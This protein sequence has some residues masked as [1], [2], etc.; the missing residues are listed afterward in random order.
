M[1]LNNCELKGT[2]NIYRDNDVAFRGDN[3]RNGSSIAGD[4]AVTQV[5]HNNRIL[6]YSKHYRQC[7]ADAHLHRVITA[8]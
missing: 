1:L 2:R 7:S 8:W 4:V 5:L 6:G 3:N